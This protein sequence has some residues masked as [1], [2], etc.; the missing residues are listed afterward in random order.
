MPAGNGGG[1]CVTRHATLSTES[2]NTRN[3]A[4]ACVRT[5]QKR[6]AGAKPSMTEPRIRLKIIKAAIDQCNAIA[7]EL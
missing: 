6:V 3:P 4:L 5:S 1:G 2:S 7:T